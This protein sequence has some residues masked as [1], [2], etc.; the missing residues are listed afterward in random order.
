[1]QHKRYLDPIQLVFINIIL[2]SWYAYVFSTLLQY[3]HKGCVLLRFDNC[4]Y[5]QYFVELRQRTDQAYTLCAIMF[6]FTALFNVGQLLGASLPW[7]TPLHTYEQGFVPMDELLESDSHRLNEAGRV[8]FS[9]FLPMP[10]GLSKS[11]PSTRSPDN[12]TWHHIYRVTDTAIKKTHVSRLFSFSLLS[13]PPFLFFLFSF[14]WLGWNVFL[15]RHASVD[16]VA[17]LLSHLY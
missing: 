8:F 7:I 13:F 15:F 14:C 5:F 11:S 9:L 6:T 2:R 3:S 16:R 12:E 4:P 10:F 17:L 1:M